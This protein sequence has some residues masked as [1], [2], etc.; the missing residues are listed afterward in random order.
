M[1][2]DRHDRVGIGRVNRMML[3]YL[4]SLPPR[5]TK[6]EILKLLCTAGGLR[7]EQVGRIDL[8]GVNA[9]IEVP[10]DS[11]ARVVKAL[12]GSEFKARRLR[13]R[14]TGS[15]PAADVSDHFQRLARLLNLESQAEAQQILERAGQAPAERTGDSL[16]GL[17][18]VE[19]SSGLGGRFILT[20]AQRNRS[21]PLPWNRLEPG[22]PVLL[23]AT[24]GKTGEGWRG[25]V[26]ERNR[27]E[28]RVALNE[29]PG[30]DERPASYRLDLSTGSRARTP[31]WP[32]RRCWLFSPSISRN[33][34]PGR[35]NS[36][37]ASPASSA[38]TANIS[39][40]W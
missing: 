35:A 21:L 15:V 7:R 36:G 19:E 34:D 23:S 33:R 32:R 27:M 3:I 24:G 13:A 17:V 26:C 5:T 25:I 8:H 2:H 40:K 30:D 6:G 22:A 38:P 37:R 10:D 12:D 20:L 29:P 18:A 1:G 16:V 39:G 14:S 28:L 11:A 4:E 9:A 31:K